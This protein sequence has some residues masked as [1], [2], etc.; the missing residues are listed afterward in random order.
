M[1][2]SMGSWLPATSVRPDTATG[3]GACSTRRPITSLS[4][5]QRLP[6]GPNALDLSR[7]IDARNALSG[8]GPLA[9]I[10]DSL[11]ATKGRRGPEAGSP[12]RDPDRPD[13]R[14]RTN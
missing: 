5:D 13:P 6:P 1:V 14:G 10:A 7:R 4:V 9:S 3:V 8:E 11:G 12:G 2:G